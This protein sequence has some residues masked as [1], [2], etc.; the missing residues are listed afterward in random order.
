MNST[1]YA[2]KA[3]RF[4]AGLIPSFERSRIVEDVDMLRSEVRDNL[5][6]AFKQAA[7]QMASKK[8][9]SKMVADFNEVFGMTLPDY[10]RMGYFEG[11]A[12][13]YASLIEK[14]DLID[15]LVMELFAKDVTKETLTYRKTAIL[16]Y[17][18]AIRFINEYS[19]RCL[20]RLLAA[21]SLTLLGKADQ[22]DRQLAPAEI[23]WLEE[24]R[25]AYMQA[26][27]LLAIPV[28][29]LNAA[30]DTIPEITVVPERFQQ[31]AATVGLHKLDP[32]QLGLISAQWNPIYHLR[33]Y[34][35]E[36]QVE[37]YRRNKELKRA[38]ELRLLALREAQAGKQDARLQ[39][40]IE[41]TEARIARLNHEIAEMERQYA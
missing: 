28:K 31:V 8:F 26:L 11:M 19:S 37:Q 18:S 23:K 25:S 5:L 41:Y 21:E 24:N 6:P 3:L 39:Q 17:L 32:L 10:R 27:K 9:S 20:L 12:H 38:L 40:Q 35:A 34:F 36:R 13:F 16:Q 4:F 29:D 14:L 2:A 33:S 22:V 15:R 1:S 30:F 7:S